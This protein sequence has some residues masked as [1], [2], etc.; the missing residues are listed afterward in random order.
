[1]ER[2]GDFLLQYIEGIEPNS[3][4]GSLR[5]RRVAD[6]DHQKPGCAGLEH[7]RSRNA[8]PEIEM[9]HCPRHSAR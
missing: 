8:A 6:Y 3:V 5:C 4:T 2:L 1:M 9:G 7:V